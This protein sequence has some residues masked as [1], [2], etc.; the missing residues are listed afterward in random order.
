MLT[1]AASILPQLV[2]PEKRKSD[3]IIIQRG[4]GEEISNAIPCVLCKLKT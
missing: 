3:S 1:S 4:E 2:E